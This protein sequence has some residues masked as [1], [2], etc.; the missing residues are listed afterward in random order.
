[1]AGG[2]TPGHPRNWCEMQQCVTLEQR[3]IRPAGVPFVVGVWK[4][5]GPHWPSLPL[6]REQQCQTWWIQVYWVV[7]RLITALNRGQDMIPHTRKMVGMSRICSGAEPLMWPARRQGCGE[8]LC[9][10]TLPTAL[11]KAKQ[12]FIVILPRWRWHGPC[13]NPPKWPSS[14][15]HQFCAP[16]VGA[17]SILNVC[18]PAL[19]P[20]PQTLWKELTVA[21]PVLCLSRQLWFW[22]CQFAPSISMKNK[23]QTKKVGQELPLFPL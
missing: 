22:G 2:A 20:P 23:L 14:V 4:L 9:K 8:I 18:A 6:Q 1:M 10:D 16:L 12:Y 5:C 7:W 15:F 11:P 21:L 17:G 13:S 19:L 3:T